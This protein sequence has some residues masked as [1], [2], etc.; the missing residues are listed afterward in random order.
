MMEWEF[1]APYTLE[2]QKTTRFSLVYLYLQ[3]RQIRQS[4]ARHE[5]VLEFS[6]PS[7][8]VLSTSLVPAVQLGLMQTVCEII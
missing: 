7:R 6:C 3:T 1:L 8:S 4:P 5:Q 2:E